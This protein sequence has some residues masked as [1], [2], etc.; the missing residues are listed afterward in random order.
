MKDTLASDLVAMWQSELTAMA[1]D[2][3]VREGW[4][5]LLALW[6]QSASTAASLLAH[7][8][9]RGSPGAP[10]PARAAPAAAAPQPGLAEVEQLN[11]RV[12]ELEQR[13]AELLA[14]DGGRATAP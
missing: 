9:A 5:T 12:A 3:E 1:A 14:R 10:Q 13:L 2:R 6:A 11:R 8:S 4:A 7:D